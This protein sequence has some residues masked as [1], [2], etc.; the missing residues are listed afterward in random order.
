MG[1]KPTISMIHTFGCEAT[2]HIHHDLCQKLDDHSIPGIHIGIAQGKKAFLIYDPQTQK[3]HES[4]D[5]HFFEHKKEVSEQVTIEVESFDS[6]TH[7]VIPTKDEVSVDVHHVDKPLHDQG[8]D[9]YV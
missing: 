1:N 9:S 7:V 4:R 2:L 5:V 3:I 8:N 6:P